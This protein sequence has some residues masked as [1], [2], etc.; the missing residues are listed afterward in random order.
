MV[1][2]TFWMQYSA[3]PTN[4]GSSHL[5]PIIPNSDIPSQSAARGERKL[6][7]FSRKTEVTLEDGIF[8]F[9]CSRPCHLSPELQEFGVQHRVSV[10]VSNIMDT[11]EDFAFASKGLLSLFT[12]G[13]TLC[14]WI[15]FIN[16]VSIPVSAD[17][18][19]GP[20]GISEEE[21]KLWRKR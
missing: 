9:C 5:V 16:I 6:K 18:N 8:G 2:L 17:F 11:D 19:F 14:S 1:V 21:M 3:S 10:W 15:V 20:S 13:E 12:G 7:W 4:P